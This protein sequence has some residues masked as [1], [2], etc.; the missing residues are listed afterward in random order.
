MHITNLTTI[1]LSLE[2]VTQWEA[3]KTHRSAIREPPQN[4]LPPGWANIACHGHSPCWA[5]IPPTIREPAGLLPQLPPNDEKEEDLVE[6]QRDHIGL[7][8]R[9]CMSLDVTFSY[10]ITILSCNNKLT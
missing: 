8:G 7:P 6:R 4:W 5:W 1:W 2:P 3:V 9:N 10:V